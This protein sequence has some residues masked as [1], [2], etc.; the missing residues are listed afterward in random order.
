M[1][2]VLSPQ[3]EAVEWYRRCHCRIAGQGVYRLSFSPVACDGARAARGTAKRGILS[4]CAW[5]L[6]KNASRKLWNPVLSCRM[7]RV[8][9]GAPLS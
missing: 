5:F 1:P 9:A 4:R 7:A 2:A 6:A 8:F 3:G